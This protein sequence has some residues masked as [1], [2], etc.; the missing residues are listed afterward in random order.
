MRINKIKKMIEPGTE[1]PITAGQKVGNE[2]GIWAEGKLEEMGYPINRGK[3]PDLPGVEHKTRRAGTTSPMTIG[4]TTTDELISTPWE[5]ST[6]RDKCQQIAITNWDENL[7]ITLGTDIIDLRNEAC[8][9]VLRDAYENARKSILNG[10]DESTEV[11]G[12]VY[13]E[14]K[15]KNGWQMRVTS[16]GLKRM[17]S[18][19]WGQ[20]VLNNKEL[21]PDA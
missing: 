1:V 5:Q 14:K 13:F 17:K 11:D 4:R 9:S 21:F 12:D 3:G 6:L 18:R 20:D 10:E 16:G 7:G 19:A 2:I 8:Q 15:S